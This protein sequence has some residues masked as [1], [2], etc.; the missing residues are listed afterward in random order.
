MMN[1]NPDD[2]ER[3]DSRWLRPGDG[4]VPELSSVIG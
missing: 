2:V 3:G 1:R 4:S